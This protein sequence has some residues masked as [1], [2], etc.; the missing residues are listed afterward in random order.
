MIETFTFNYI[1][2]Q[3]PGVLADLLCKF[4]E[5]IRNFDRCPEW[6]QLIAVRASGK[7]V[8]YIR[9]PS[10]RVQIA[11]V[12]SCPDAYFL[13]KV[14]SGVSISD[15]VKSNAFAA[16]YIST[17]DLGETCKFGRKIGFLP[18]K[19]MLKFIDLQS[20]LNEKDGE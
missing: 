15:E 13:L 1:L 18:S 3:Y 4:P 12:R 14:P 19:K 11:A 10:E 2:S 9:E 7:A 6:V 5:I 8:V 17:G 16:K 20:R